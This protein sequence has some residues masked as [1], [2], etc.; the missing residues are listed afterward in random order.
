MSNIVPD[1]PY[2]A[3]TTYFT[4]TG[5]NA[6]NNSIAYTDPEPN[7][8]LLVSLTGT[9]S[10]R[11]NGTAYNWGTSG[12][13]PKCFVPTRTYN[14]RLV[15][16][17]GV[18]PFEPGI[19]LDATYTG[20]YLNWY[21][22]STPTNWGAGARRKPGTSQRIEIARTAAKQLVD[23]LINVRMG[24]AT[25]DS[26]N[27]ANI[28]IGVNDLDA[29]QKTALKTAIDTLL[30]SSVTPLAE[31]LQDIGRYFVQGFNNT[32]TLHPDNA[33]RLT[34]KSAYTV[35]DHAPLYA[36]GVL[37][38]SPIQYFCQKNFA[39]LLTDGRPQSVLPSTSGRCLRNTND[40]CGLLDYIGACPHGNDGVTCGPY[41]RK[42]G[43]TYESAG[44]DYMDDVASALYDM[45]LRPDLNDFDGHAVKNNIITYTIGFADDQ[46]IHDPLLQ[47]T[48]TQG[49]GLFLIAQNS[50]Q[51]ATAFQTAVLDIQHR[52]SS[53]ASVALNSGS[54]NA[55]S[56]IYQAR[57]N[58]GN[59]SGELLSF[60]INAD[61]EI[62]TEEWN[63]GSVV[64]SQNYDTGR[65]ILTFNPNTKAGVPFRWG[66]LYS[67]QQTLLN[68][69]PS[70][71]ADTQGQAR[72]DY[73]RGSTAHEG[74]GNNYR[75]RISHLGD[76]VSSNPFFVGAPAFPDSLGSGYSSFRSTYKTRTAMVYAGGNDGMLHGF[77]A[78]DGS[79]KLA[80]VP[81]KVFAK[82]SK[83]TSP[84]YGQQSIV[85][86]QFY[87][88]G[89]PTVADAY[90]DF[91]TRCPSTSPCWRSILISGL[92]KGGQGFFALDVT[93]P[94]TF[95]ESNAANRVLWEF[96]DADD[97]DLGYSFSQPSIVKMA[98]GR[99]AAVF[100]NGYNNSEADGASTTSTT[101]HAVLYIVFLD[102]FSDGIWTAGTDFIKLDTGVG[103]TATPNGLAT[104][105]AVDL[106]GNFMVNLIYAG[107]LQ[108]NMWRF[109]VSSSNPSDWSATAPIK[110]FTGTATQPIT[111]R[112][113]VGPNPQGLAPSSAGVMVYFGTGQYLQQADISTTSSQTFY[114][115]LDKLESNPTLITRGSLVAQTV[116]SEASGRRV[117]TNNPVDW[118][119]K[120]GWYF[121]LPTSG[122]R[123]VSDPILRNQR[124]IFTTTIPD[125][126]V[127]SFGG[128]S[129][130]MEFNALNGNRLETSPFDLNNDHVVNDADK[131]T[132]TISGQSQTVA[133]SGVQSTQGIL[134]TP[135]IL[136][137]GETEIKYNSGSTGGIF[138]TTEDPGPWA[139]GRLAWRQL[140]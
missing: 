33:T 76:L 112:P 124:I 41:G 113:E 83:L 37:Q 3:N 28:L 84:D 96:T 66:Q 32:L 34:T 140:Q 27:G 90:G 2:D 43:Q 125:A 10:F 101:G 46:A 75:T 133:V 130:L 79:E 50:A 81:N 38:Q 35:F 67:S 139:R 103:T 21:F 6:L 14:A 94:S 29:V 110:I 105:A 48:A 78:S 62:L 69:T 40:P 99:W 102:G 108:G 42:I 9:P 117:T 71:S 123:Q 44:T 97:K 61:G 107:D 91:G 111:T 55:N 92:R 89:S 8:D 115:M 119:T 82:L 114:G 98:N 104:P 15:A 88:D 70:G 106:D 54:Q 7:V 25:Y 120:R 20:N 77:A 118:T 122:E 85:P 116:V 109:N 137:S 86:H 17:S 19:Y 52:I 68:T 58:S 23:S 136:S 56:R 95:S 134:P 127:C 47:S 132:V 5:S 24:L 59:W 121:D 22:G 93:D 72:L 126:R 18:S 80:Y 30:P 26:S 4:C 138:M 45:D 12:T 53:T 36:T 131:I 65:T 63:A 49:G 13:S 87:A 60:P 31:S 100:G 73:L 1:T 51:L 57:F 64:T 16:D 74:T 39:V 11:Y 135:T 128:T 129:W